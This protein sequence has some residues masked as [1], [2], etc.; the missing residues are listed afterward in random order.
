M[1]AASVQRPL[2]RGARLVTRRVAVG[3]G[4]VRPFRALPR[5]SFGAPSVRHAFCYYTPVRFLK[6]TAQFHLYSLKPLARST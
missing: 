1:G 4:L 6:E 5:L 3:A 2:A